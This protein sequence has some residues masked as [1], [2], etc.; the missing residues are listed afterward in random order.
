MGVLKPRK[1]MV[2]LRLAE[3]EYERLIELCSVEGAHSASDLAR[4]AV[5]DYLLSR[6]KKSGNG[7]PS[8]ADLHQKVAK[9]EKEVRRL[10]RMAASATA[11]GR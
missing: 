10:S 7:G 6:D 1:K 5:C 3:D 9:L 11:G 4:T 2:S 8:A